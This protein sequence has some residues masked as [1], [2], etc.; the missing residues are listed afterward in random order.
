MLVKQTVTKA[1]DPYQSHHGKR[2]KQRFHTIGQS[3]ENLLIISPNFPAVFD[4]DKAGGANTI[5]RSIHKGLD[6]S[7]CGCLRRTAVPEPPTKP[8]YELK[9]ENRKK[10]EQF[11]LDYFASSAFNKC[12]H[13]QLPVLSGEP[14]HILIDPTHMKPPVANKRASNP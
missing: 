8:P 5:T 13:Q 9:M 2:I 1:Q 3:L 12:E 11:M 6:I 14:M 4:Y 7:D 10:L